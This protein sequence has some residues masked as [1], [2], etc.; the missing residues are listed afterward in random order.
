MKIRFGRH[1][2]KL[3][4]LFG[5][6][7]S[8]ALAIVGEPI[9][10]HRLALKPSLS[11]SLYLGRGSDAPDPFSVLVA[12]QDGAIQHAYRVYHSEF[13][14]AAE[15][16]PDPLGI[17]KAFV[18]VYGSPIRFGGRFG[19]K[20]K[21]FEMERVAMPPGDIDPQPEVVLKPAGAPPL[22]DVCWLYMSSPDPQARE[23]VVGL[24]FGIDLDRY[25]A[26]LAMHEST[27][28]ND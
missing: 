14:M 9:A 10:Q 26:S 8:F 15:A 17:L 18:E 20:A 24:A 4:K 2:D 21:Y 3:T 7:R 11:V 25:A 28:A 16:N 12:V 27:S 23:L 19:R 13:P 6:S 22:K 1:Y 5:V